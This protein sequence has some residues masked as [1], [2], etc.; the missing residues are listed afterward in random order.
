MSNYGKSRGLP[1]F[2]VPAFLLSIYNYTIHFRLANFRWKNR[3]RTYTSRQN[4]ALFNWT[5]FNIW[6]G[7]FCCSTQRHNIYIRQYTPARTLSISGL[8]FRVFKLS[9]LTLK[10]MLKRGLEFILKFTKPL[11]RYLLSCKAD[12]AILGRYFCTGQQQL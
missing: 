2:A 8:K 11:Q 1:G 9:F 7:F 5:I 12:S 3:R 10:M 4:H 6:S